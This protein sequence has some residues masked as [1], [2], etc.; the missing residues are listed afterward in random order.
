MVRVGYGGSDLGFGVD[1]DNLE[2]VRLAVLVC[3]IGRTVLLSTSDYVEA[4]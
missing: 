1:Y 3:D 4:V 2:A